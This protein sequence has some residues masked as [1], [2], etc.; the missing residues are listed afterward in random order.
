MFLMRYPGTPWRACLLTNLASIEARS[1]AY[2]GAL[3]MWQ[4]AWT[5]AKGDTRA[6]ATAVADT[7]VAEWLTLASSFG[8]VERVAERVADLRNRPIAGRAGAKVARARE[9]LGLLE[10]E[11]SRAVLCAAEALMALLAA[12]GRS[13]LPAAVAS[14]RAGASGTSL[15]ELRTLAAGVGVPLR[16]VQRTSAAALPVPAIVHFRIGHYATVV[17]RDGDRYQIDDRGRETTYWVTRD[18][19]LNESS[20]Y[21]LVPESHQM[22]DDWR[23]VADEEASTV[24]GWSFNCPP[25]SPPENPP[26][27]ECCPVG[28]GGGP[29][30]GPSPGMASYSLQ[31]NHREPAAARYAG[32]LHT[33]PGSG[34]AADAGLPPARAD[35]AADLHLRERRAEVE[36]RVG[37]VRPGSP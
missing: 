22:S 29:G 19:L 14:Y 6:T 11:R 7:A 10:R 30:C 35:A 27:T 21:V 31:K 8:L 37:P 23:D 28:G 18:T 15:V 9:I 17:A 4:Q 16:I 32:R 25:G 1:H 5:L 33:A 12:T 24:Y 36:L 26:C 34:R 13:D 2:A 20:G 3:D